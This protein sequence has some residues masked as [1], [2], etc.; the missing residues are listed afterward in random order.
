MTVDEPAV[1]AAVDP[2]PEEL[3]LQVGV[4]LLCWCV[5]RANNI[6]CSHALPDRKLGGR[7]EDG[8]VQLTCKREGHQEHHPS[9]FQCV[10][11]QS[12]FLSDVLLSLY[13]PPSMRHCSH[14]C[15]CHV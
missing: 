4:C 6:P 1:R 11:W 5:I 14:F 3:S 13:L 12:E 8:Q 15:T 10:L 9:C 2:Q 7:R